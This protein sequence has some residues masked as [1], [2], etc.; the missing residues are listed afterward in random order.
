M[1]EQEKHRRWNRWDGRMMGMM[2][3]VG[4]MVQVRKRYRGEEEEKKDKPDRESESERERERVERVNSTIGKQHNDGSV[5][6]DDEG[7]D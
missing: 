3:K 5:D 6:I 2:G 7:N 4:M 1:L